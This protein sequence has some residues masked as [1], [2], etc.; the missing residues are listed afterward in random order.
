M[1]NINFIDI[2]YAQNIKKKKIILYI[3]I[4]LNSIFLL[5]IIFIIYLEIII[6][7]DKKI[8]EDLDN[9]IFNINNDSDYK[10]I[11]NLINLNYKIENTAEI[12]QIVE[13]NNYNLEEEINYIVNNS[14]DYVNI[15]EINCNRENKKIEVV[16]SIEDIKKIYI[17]LEKLNEKDYFTKIYISNIV[18]KE[19]KNIIYLDLFMNK[20]L[21]R[22]SN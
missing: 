6:H 5:S 15:L 10:Y 13:V 7:K 18:S 22:K 12:L 19:N 17:F 3:I 4:L 20:S 16:F 14:R 21:E 9:S 2:V 8:I 11:Q 1:K